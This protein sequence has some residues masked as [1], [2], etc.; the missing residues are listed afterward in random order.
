MTGST[1]RPESFD[2]AL[3]ERF[4]KEAKA[5]GLTLEEILESRIRDGGRVHAEKNIEVVI[6]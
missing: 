2:T 4:T 1:C 3:R 6:G 5:V